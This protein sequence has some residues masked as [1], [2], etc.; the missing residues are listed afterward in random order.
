MPSDPSPGRREPAEWAALAV[1]NGLLSQIGGPSWLNILCGVA[2]VASTYFA[3][4]GAS[5]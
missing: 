5:R 4:R 2:S 3:V 1:A